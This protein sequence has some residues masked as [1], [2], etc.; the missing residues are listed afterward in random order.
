MPADVSAY[1]A[2]IDKGGVVAILVALVLALVWAARWLLAQ[3]L[4]GKDAAIGYRDSQLLALATQ[5]SRQ[6][7]LFDQALALLKESSSDRHRR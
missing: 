7:D 3:V 4:S 2:L 5:L 1:V 6:Q